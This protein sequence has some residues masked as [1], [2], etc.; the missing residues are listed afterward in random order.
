MHAL[1]SYRAIHYHVP[2]YHVTVASFQATA[3]CLRTRFDFCTPLTYLDTHTQHSHCTTPRLR[4]GLHSIQCPTT[5]PHCVTPPLC[6]RCT[7][8]R[9][10]RFLA[11]PW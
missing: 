11:L 1:P 7:T 9:A 6:T 4:R 8:L 2:L 5:V 10:H 3:G